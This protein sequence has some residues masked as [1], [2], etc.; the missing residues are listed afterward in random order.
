LIL[1]GLTP[2]ER[3]L[4][5]YQFHDKPVEFGERV[6]GLRYTP[7]VQRMMRSVRDNVFTLARS[8]NATGKTHGAASVIT[9]FYKVHPQSR[10]YC[11]SAPPEDNLRNLLW[12]EVDKIVNA[13]PQLFEADRITDLRIARNK[14]SFITGVTIPVSANP[15]EREARFSGKHAPQM[16]FVIDEGDAVPKEVYAGIESCISG[17]VIV[18]V[19]VLF[20]PRSDSGPIPQK[21][22]DGE[23]NVVTLSAFDHPN[24]VT[25]DDKAFPG[26]VTRERTVARINRWS[27][28]LAEGEE[29]DAECFDVPEF[30]VGYVAHND[31]GQPYPP[32][33]AGVRRITDSKLS[34]MVLAQ[35]PAQSED[36]LISHVWIEAAR[37]RYDAWQLEHGNTPPWG[38]RPVQGL[39]VAG[40][41][42]LNASCLRYGVYV[43][44]IETWTGVD[45]PVTEQK[46][47]ER[48]TQSNA[49]A[50]FVDATGLGYGVAP[51]LEIDFPELPPDHVAYGVMVAESP[52]LII[53]D[54]QFAQMRDQLM[55]L[56]REWFRRDL[57]MIPPSERLMESLRAIKYGRDK[58]MKIKMTKKEDLVDT[59]GY[60]PDEME[61]LM[62]TFYNEEYGYEDE[63]GALARALTDRGR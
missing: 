8:G 41:G 22:R 14:N 13:N 6:L 2:P 55:W 16:L 12:A 29:R 18:R 54:G 59:L 19:L 62:L 49:R 17:G 60:S 34:Y 47:A 45:T 57:A 11:A 48:A 46:A 32:L 9:W 44:P 56:M 21:E 1:T 25:G 24:V 43:P 52:T 58:K 36:Q 51:H 35:Y 27:R 7:D 61:A 3:R 28:P 5:L 26:A 10:V 33:P 30:L 63:G 23:A 4:D 37:A 39:D 40:T 15:K 31:R 53:E 50:T 20:N 38:V 42:D